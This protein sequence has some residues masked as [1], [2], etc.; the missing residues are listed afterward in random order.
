MNGLI[1]MVDTV[2]LNRGSVERSE[3]RIKNS[4]IL[5][6]NLA[7]KIISE[8]YNFRE[9]KFRG[10]CLK[11][12]SVSFLHKNIVNLH[13]TYELHT[14]SKDLNTDFTLGNCLFGA[15]KLTNNADSDK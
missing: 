5:D 7:S 11:Q 6:V 4:L 12:E 9:A 14:W 2:E 15:V 13:I 3:G 10:I 8:Y 1:I